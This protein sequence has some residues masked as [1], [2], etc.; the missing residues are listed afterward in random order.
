M[1]TY[2]HSYVF[3]YILNKIL[4]FPKNVDYTIFRSISHK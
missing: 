2:I 4:D 1:D 3:E